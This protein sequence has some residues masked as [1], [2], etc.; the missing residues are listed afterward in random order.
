MSG[1]FVNGTPPFSP[2]CLPSS[3]PKHHPQNPSLM[4]CFS[5]F[6]SCALA[7]LACKNSVTCRAW[8]VQPWAGPAAGL[9]DHEWLA[10]REAFGQCGATEALSPRRPSWLGSSENGE[11]PRVG[12]VEEGCR[13]REKAAFNPKLRPVNC[14]R[15]DLWRGERL[16]PPTS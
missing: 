10:P 3:S 11:W 8:I 5:P 13:N 12:G 2:Q 9:A 15:G 14:E 7:L 6:S 16:F 1:L 4:N